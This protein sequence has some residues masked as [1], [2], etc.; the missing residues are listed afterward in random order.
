MQTQATSAAVC[1]ECGTRLEG[2]FSRNLGRCMICLLRVGFDDAEEPD[3]T[4]FAP[5]TD[6]LGNY[7]IERHDDGTLWE[8]GRGAMGVTYQAVDTSLQRPVALKL[9][10]SEWVKRGVEARERFMR[11]ARTAAALRHPNVATVYHFGIREE[12]GQCFCAMELVEGETL[13]TRVRR[14]GPLDALTTIEIALQVSSAL[15]AAEKQGLVHRDL[16][17]ANL[18]VVEAAA[19]PLS[20][21]NDNT[22][23]AS[24]SSR[25]NATRESHLLVKVIDFGVAK[26]LA[27]KP[28][29]MGL[30]HGGFVG[31]PAF[32]SPE[33]FTDAP[34]GV[35]SD[36][37][38]L[39]ATL[40]YLLTGHRPFKG[41]TIE[42]IRASQ[43]SRALPIEQLKAARV[44][45]R[46]I[47][48]LVSM[49][50][51]HPA[52]R[53]DVRTLT[54]QLQDC[55]AQ[56]LDRW[57]IM[58][59]SALAAAWVSLA[60]LAAV[61]FFPQ[62][63]NQPL[64][65]VANASRLPPK[66]IAV[67]P[68]RN[69]SD[70]KENAFFADGIQDDLVTSLARIKDL[71]VVS[72]GSVTSYRDLSGRSLR[73]V[74]QELGVGAV[75]EGSVRRTA[76]RVLVN[77]Q[78]TDAT[79]ERQ[80]WSDR[81]DRTL[82]DS[83]ALQGELAAEI[84]TALATKLS[85]EEKAQVEAKLTNNPDAYVVYLR[86][87]EFQMRPEVSRDNYVAAEQCYRH[88]VA[89]DSRFA[90]AHAR[91][92]EI[93]EGRYGWFDN[94]P[95][96]LAEA[97]SH[98]EEAL[99]LDPHCGQA[100]MEM[101]H[102]LSYSVKSSE[103][104][105]AIK[106][107]LD[108]ALRLVPNDGYLV[109]IAA[110]FQT[111][112]EWLEEAEATFQRAIEINPREPK[113][114][115][116]YFTLLTKKGDVAKARWASDRSM[117]LAPESVYFRLNRASEEFLWTG[118]VARTKK[119][120]AEIPAGRDPDGRVTAAYCTA[121]VY[122]RNFPEV[123][124]LLAA[125]PSERLPCF[126]GRFGN[127]V[128]KGFLEGWIHFYAGNKERAFTALDSVR[129]IL[130]KEAK[131]NPGD[132]QA[133]FYVA[134]TYA[135]MG[136][137]DA[138]LAEIARAKEKPNAWPLAAFLVYAGEHDVALRQLEQVP[139][140]E[141]EYWYYDLCLNPHWDPLRSDARFEKLLAAS[142][143]KT[144]T[145]PEKSIAI[146]PFE[147]RSEDKENAF[148]ADGMQ[149]DVL[150]SLV[151]VKDLK[152]IGGSSVMSY[153]DTVNRNLREIGR[154]L[155]VVHVLE[156]SVQRIA[157]RLLVHVNLT[158]TRDGRTLLAE[159]Y[160]RT[161]AD[162]TGLQGELAAD[163]AGALRATLGPGEKARLQARTTRNPDAY[164]LY[165]RGREYQMRPEVSQ[166]NYLAAENFYK[167]AV[168]LD[169][170]F[171]LA[172]A[173]LAEMQLWLYQKFFITRPARIAEA[174]STAEEALRLDPDCGQAHMV[175]AGCMMEA[176]DSTAAMRREVA[177]AVRLL[178][179]D[180]YIALAV[181]MLQKDMGW[182]DEAAASFERAMV[183]NPRE[184]KVFYNYSTLFAEKDIPDIS[185]SRWASD[186][187]LE[188]SP[189]SIFFRL[190]RASCELEWTGEVARSKAV[191]A[192]LPAGKDPDGRVTAAHCTIALYERD[193]PE[194]LRL[195]AACQLE[196][197]PFLDGGF[198]W[199]VPK[200]FV[201]G[202]VHF[203]AGH[204]EE[205][206]ASLDSVRWMLEIE[207]QESEAQE[208]AGQAEA[209]YHLALAYA[210]MGWS[211]A[212]KA[213]ISRSYKKP[214][215]GQKATVFA[216]L[217][218]HDSAL[219][220]LEQ[221][222]S[223]WRSARTYLR[224]DPRWDSLRGDPRFEKLLAQ[225][226]GTGN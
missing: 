59:R 192:G 164:L 221:A 120:L 186:R 149:D 19:P 58:R 7:R 205:A 79:T 109:M 200:G 26:A 27:E 131:E 140:R 41:A 194:A 162:S 95:A 135:A 103:R 172:R 97:R 102:I 36:I 170:L 28:D 201:E 71:K 89:L 2:G 125:C 91:L 165:L 196:R 98:A 188:L 18:M 100:H 219:P 34:V 38:S 111:D 48:L 75:L 161:I 110:L 32:A 139:A 132:M 101:A 174:R 20:S 37:Y 39:G 21:S 144:A 30:T 74:A 154:Q 10:A 52:A 53:P 122:E 73:A 123:L 148:L 124:R 185:R 151:Q 141:R 198:G 60:I 171:A 156:G 57:K 168:A 203:W 14:T 90:L 76:N 81:Y 49:L 96:L 1:P 214:D 107:E 155:N 84:A 63:R 88:A 108:S 208:T 143:P 153:R 16:K 134:L 206:Y 40:W 152:V 92:A 77:V 223:A 55:R 190:N 114:F 87:R 3:E 213:Q 31:T 11:E 183:L 85:P 105:N 209:H 106:Q 216:L 80:I 117:E 104:D 93:L 179:N 68:F 169:P 82:K 182:N 119:F 146:L 51:L 193:F 12:N 215:I 142:A 83:I 217:G 210:A 211:D 163:I 70:D 225:N 136:W 218:D 44:P 66:S 33:Q 137:K 78:L 222:V 94:H 220:L 45:S 62:K 202:L 86:G 138:A 72:R 130:E 67:L 167:Q 64:S 224:L 6:R 226:A 35:R 8:L 113:V 212:A 61:W 166:D 29:A 65:G 184:G 47:S 128:P 176:G 69:L 17:P 99:R 43:R 159:R 121:A 178:P 180:A 13:E 115:Y 175:L 197:I 189:D 160:D 56:I 54:L 177:A 24:H 133:H 15:S 207:A 157:N 204:L 199:M 173:R 23:R 195:L 145:V 118:E 50:S 150:T 127:M 147:N 4:S 22:T 9:I 46:L 25:K 112:M 181:A 116:N 126:V 42:Q 187:A 191:L 129:W 158:D 5:V